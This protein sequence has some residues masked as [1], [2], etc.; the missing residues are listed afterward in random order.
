MAAM[1]LCILLAKKH[2]QK[3]RDATSERVFCAKRFRPISVKVG[4]GE[5][6]D[7]GLVVVVDGAAELGDGA[8]SPRQGVVAGHA[9]LERKQMEIKFADSNKKA[10]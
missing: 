2:G 3:L 7:E 10:N 4:V 6:D 9:E 5:D 8:R 1:Y